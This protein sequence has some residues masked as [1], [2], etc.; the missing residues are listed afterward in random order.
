MGNELEQL[1]RFELATGRGIARISSSDVS[2]QI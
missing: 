2:G 1:R